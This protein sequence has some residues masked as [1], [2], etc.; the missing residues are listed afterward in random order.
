MRVEVTVGGGVCA[1]LGAVG[2]VGTAGEIEGLEGPP[3][4]QCHKIGLRQLAE[5]LHRLHT[6]GERQVSQHM[7]SQTDQSF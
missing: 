7:L 5:S 4:I 1:T 2:G 3:A 6:N